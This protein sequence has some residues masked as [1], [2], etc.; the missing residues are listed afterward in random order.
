M[1]KRNGFLL[2]LFVLLLANIPLNS[3]TW[4]T[5]TCKNDVQD[6]CCVGDYC[7]VAT[8]GGMV[9]VNINDFSF[10]EYEAE[11]GLPES[12][13]NAIISDQNKIW[14]GSPHKG[15]SLLNDNIWTSYNSANSGLTN[16]T[17]NC[18]AIDNDNKLW[19]GSNNCIIVF[20]GT[21]WITYTKNDYG[22]NDAIFNAIKIDS[23]GKVWAGTTKGLAVFDGISWQTFTKANSGLQTNLVSDIS[24]DANKVWLATNGAGIHYYENDQWINY[25]KENSG[26][27]ENYIMCAFVDEKEKKWFGSGYG[28]IYCYDDTTWT[29]FD[30]TNCILSFD[31]T[32]VSNPTAIINTITEDKNG[33]LWVGG[34]SG[35]YFYNGTDWLKVTITGRLETKFIT[36]IAV[37]RQNNKWY[38]TSKHGVVVDRN[39]S[40]QT[41]NKT[42]SSLPYDYINDITIDSS[43]NVL[44]ATNWGVSIY[45]GDSL[46]TMN[47]SDDGIPFVTVRSIAVDREGNVWYGSWNSCVYKYDGSTFSSYCDPDNKIKATGV[48][49]IGFD[50][51]NNKWFCTSDIDWI[52]GTKAFGIACYNDSNWQFYKV[53][54][55]IYSSNCADAVAMENNGDLWFGTM[56]GVYKYDGTN[57]VNYNTSNSGLL[58]NWVYTMTIDNKGRKWFGSDGGG[59]CMFDGEMWYAYLPENS[60]IISNR[61][62]ALAAD[63]YGNVIIGTDIGVSIYKDTPTII[64]KEAN[65]NVPVNVELS[66]NYPNP[67]NSETKIQY[68]LSQKGHVILQVYNIYGQLVTSLYDG[69]QTTGNH[70]VHWQGVNSCGETVASGIYFYR[71]KLDGRQTQTRRLVFLK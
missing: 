69:E 57:W 63:K 43:G 5:F 46:R 39:G 64:N 10:E 9:K 34:T 6:L 19:I 18:L 8:T 59:L 27:L 7:W 3:Q 48:M 23:E 41:Y 33:N 56:G 67:F 25:N 14:F 51:H 60:Q 54:K 66:Q 16:N 17:I 28:R 32:F 49:D 1:Y 30:S 71:L 11:E 58:F 50:K 12:N 15:L 45:N 61:I 35:L 42:N 26:L 2:I 37:D 53:N 20:D 24:Y 70:T 21:N 40:W 36:A 29:I 31:S 22:L 44:I 38:G 13:I 4:E 47:Q 65:T 68:H 52:L 55:S 62:Q